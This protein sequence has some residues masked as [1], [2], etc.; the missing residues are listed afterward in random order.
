MRYPNTKCCRCGEPCYIRPG[1]LARQSVWFCSNKCWTEHRNSNLTATCEECGNMYKRRDS[2]GKYCSRSCSNRA[3]KGIKYDGTRPNCKVQMGQ[4]IRKML[5][6]RDGRVCGAEGCDVSTEWNKKPIKLQIEH[7]DGNR[8]N[9]K[10]DNLVYLCPNCHSQTET[11]GVPKSRLKGHG[12]RA[13]LDT[14]DLV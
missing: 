13:G 7:I 12:A 1:Q 5:D 14:N 10:S 6:R 3:R 8:K 11:W 9:N 4:R 2:G